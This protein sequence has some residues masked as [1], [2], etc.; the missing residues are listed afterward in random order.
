[1]HSD[2][3]L[4]SWRLT[5]MVEAQLKLNTLS[6][7]MDVKRELLPP[8]TIVV[9]WKMG[10]FKMVVFLTQESFSTEQWIHWIYCTIMAQALLQFS[11]TL[12]RSHFPLRPF[13]WLCQWR[14]P[15]WR[16]PSGAWRLA[17]WIL[18]FIEFLQ[19]KTFLRTFD[20]LEFLLRKILSD[21]V[22]T[23][24]TLFPGVPFWRAW[25]PLTGLRIVSVPKG[26]AT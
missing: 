4:W 13:K 15:W 7:L 14:N 9:L 24:V 11:C 21:E 17:P 12:P 10:A 1:M 16:P 8:L 2:S 3:C 20:L 19:K 25:K 18:G 6:M 26:L 22:C 23:L 5:R